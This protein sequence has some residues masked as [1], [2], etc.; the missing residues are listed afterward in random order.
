MGIS[1]PD[2]IELLLKHY[3]INQKQLSRIADL[4]ENTIS[5]AKK[6]KNVPNLDFFN[7]IYRAFPELSHRWLYL[8]EGEIDGIDQASGGAHQNEML[9]ESLNRV[10]VQEK[11]LEFLRSQINDKEEIIRLLKKQLQFPG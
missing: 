1:V 4:S 2:R 7:N 8:G 5:N 10:K 3:N 11:E 6:G 9:E